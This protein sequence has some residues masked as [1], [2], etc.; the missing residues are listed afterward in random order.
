MQPTVGSVNNTQEVFP[1]A[2]KTVQQQEKKTADAQKVSQ[3]MSVGQAAIQTIQTQEAVKPV[4][5]S[6]YRLQ[7][8]R[9]Q[10][11]GTYIYKTLDSATGKVI[12]QIPDEQ[13]LKLKQDPNYKSGSVVSRKV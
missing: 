8:E 4:D 10:A 1:V 6:T 2:Q 9:D 12:S 13:M 7:I 3:D 11:S 5:T